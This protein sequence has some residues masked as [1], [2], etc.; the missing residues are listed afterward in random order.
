M[1]E[2]ITVYAT[3]TPPTLAPILLPCPYCRRMTETLEAPGTTL[4]YS[5]LLCSGCQRYLKWR[6][7]P[8]D[9][10]GHKLARP[11]ALEPTT[12]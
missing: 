12:E 4:H 10:A 8:R 11:L 2:S 5:K 9:S 1:D 7:W 3:R 6:P